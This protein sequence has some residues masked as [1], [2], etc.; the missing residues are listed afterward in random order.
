M[1][2]LFWNILDFKVL[3][4]N[5]DMYGSVDESLCEVNAGKITLQ[6]RMREEI[7]LFIEML[8]ARLISMRAIK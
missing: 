6:A 2:S 8:I 3:H 7:K 5:W 4:N 1:C